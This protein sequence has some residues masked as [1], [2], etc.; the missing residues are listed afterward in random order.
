MKYYFKKYDISDV[1]FEEIQ[2]RVDTRMEEKKQ[3]T[4]GERMDMTNAT[5]DCDNAAFGYA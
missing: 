2:S 1:D 3:Y 5:V 4:F